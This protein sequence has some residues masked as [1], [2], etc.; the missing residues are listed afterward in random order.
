MEKTKDLLSDFWEYI[1]DKKDNN[2]QAEKIYN[3]LNHDNLG[4][5]I[6][7][8]NIFWYE[9]NSGSVM[10]DYV[11]NYIKKYFNKKGYTYLFDI[12]PAI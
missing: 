6:L 12:V 1:E 4:A 8:E 5:I 10:P 3:W 7:D 9:M 11:Y 2:K